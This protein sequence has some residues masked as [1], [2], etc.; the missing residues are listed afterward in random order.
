MSNSI[1]KSSSTK[2]K[3]IKVKDKDEV[4]K[5]VS[6][7]KS[8]VVTGNKSNAVRK[9]PVV[10]KINPKTKSLN[11]ENKTTKAKKAVIKK[12]PNANIKSIK[13]DELDNIKKKATNNEEHKE[14]VV[15][16]EE[17]KENKVPEIKTEVK[18][19]KKEESKTVEIKEE[20]KDKDK[21]T[22]ANKNKIKMPKN[23]KLAKAASKSNKRLKSKKNLPPQEKNVK[24]VITPPEEKKE[25]QQ[26]IVIEKKDENVEIKSIKVDKIDTIK[27]KA[28]E[29]N[30]TKEKKNKDVIK[31]GKRV[32]SVY[33]PSLNRWV[34]KEDK[35]KPKETPRARK[36][37]QDVSSADDYTYE[38]E[39]GGL[40]SKFF[41]EVNVERYNEVKRKKRSKYPKRILI[42]LL[43]IVVLGTSGFLFYKRYQ[44][45]IKE[46]LN[47]YEVYNIGQE[48]KLA[49]DSIWYVVEKSDGSKGEVILLAKNCVDINGDG[50]VDL[51][52]VR[53]YSSGK[54]EYD[55]KDDTSISH[56][57]ENNYKAILA[58]KV[59]KIS[60]IAILTS[61][62]YVGIRN[63][64]GYGYEWG[65]ENILANNDTNQYFL[66]T[67][68]NGNM[69]VVIRNGTYR[70]VSPT[71]SQY[72]RVVITVEKSIIKK[73]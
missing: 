52:D 11:Q 3:T 9:K 27:K 60:D 47:M 8:T 26:P 1:K 40:K 53:P 23:R 7:N 49:D 39:T 62:Q 12:E 15:Q 57:L 67:S 44:Q 25:E 14:V 30:K 43:V 10:K 65:D 61:K 71:S 42:V 38:L 34:V 73:D 22:V 35:S 58:E 41:E 70:M 28:K 55:A 19:E 48:V 20:P 31:S 4:S 37:I 32:K 33:D 54:V 24:S 56:Y 21:K 13:V 2:T 50:V 68:Q 46:R 45:K 36:N 17:I 16:K 51:N 64:M 72:V 66:S 63:A 69:Y 59:G 5:V 6:K 29:N 18:E